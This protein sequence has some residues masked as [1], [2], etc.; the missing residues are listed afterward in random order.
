MLIARLKC[1]I[2]IE[3]DINCFSFVAQ[4][5]RAGLITVGQSFLAFIL[6]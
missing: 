1:S 2:Y 5:K 6:Y 4:R 3:T